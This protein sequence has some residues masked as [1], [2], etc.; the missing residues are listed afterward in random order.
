MFIKPVCNNL[1]IDITLSKIYNV[2]MRIRYNFYSILV[3]FCFLVANVWA[4]TLPNGVEAPCKDIT[5]HEN[6]NIK[7]AYLLEPR[8]IETPIGSF[9]FLGWIYFD[10]DTHFDGGELANEVEITTPMGCMKTNL[11]WFKNG[12]LDGIRCAEGTKIRTPIGEVELVYNHAYDGENEKLDNRANGLVEF[13]DRGVVITCAYVDINKVN[14][15][16][17]Q[18]GL[19]A[20]YGQSLAMLAFKDGEVMSLPKPSITL[21]KVLNPLIEKLS[22]QKR[23]K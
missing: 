4:V 16:I 18:K 2:S 8:E 14:V 20:I 17:I 7:E 15:P 9:I 10:E 3:L 13:D 5:K 22:I 23:D 19:F 11:I 1:S 12:K 6:G 21:K